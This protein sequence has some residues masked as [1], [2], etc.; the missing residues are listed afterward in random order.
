MQTIK[1]AYM[2][3]RNE[4]RIQLRFANV[5][6]MNTHVR[7][8]AGVRWSS[9]HK[10]W[11]LPATK[12]AFA[13]LQKNLPAGWVVQ[14]QKEESSKQSEQASPQKQVKPVLQT[15]KKETTV[16]PKTMQSKTIVQTKVLSNVL[17]ISKLQKPATHNNSTAANIISL[18]N[19]KALDEMLQ[20]LQ[21]KGYS[22]NTIRTYKSELHVFLET[23]KN[24]NVQTITPADLKRYLQYCL[25][26]LQLTE[27][28]VHSRLNALK[29]YFEQVLGR[30]KFFFTIP[31]P[32]KHLQLP[33]IISEE[34]IVTGLLQ[35]ENVKHRAILMVAYSAGLRV[36]EVVNLKVT[37]VQSDRMQ[38]FIEKS[39]GKKD[40]IVPLSKTALQ[41]L[42]AYFIAYKPNKWLFEGQNK[43]E[44]YSTRSAQIIFN[45]AFKMLG[46]AS[47]ISFHSLRH[48][49]ATHLLE[50]GTDIK[51]I[52]DLLG[53]NDIQTT[54][55]Y[56][57]V[58]NKDLRKIE[59][60]LDKIMREQEGNIKGK[61]P[62]K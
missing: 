30:E 52:Q 18:N 60:P 4:K 24:K 21:L 44:H 26:T 15:S 10:C 11:H 22:K 33:K 50:A 46:L 59:S 54:L 43:N 35:I 56:T 53:H 8:I 39:K 7:K 5:V 49:F 3:H 27:N 48:S 62:K 13:Q 20:L 32:K 23:I 17:P 28:A 2:E 6:Q 34:K 14:V 9:T 29:F 61:Q 12:A 40:R 25:D 36:S 47:S 42:R 31:R 41:V 51:Y 38:I 37:D 16:S 19:Q 1:V 58:S 55:R 45:D 57:H